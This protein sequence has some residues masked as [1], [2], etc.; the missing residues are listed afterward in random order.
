MIKHKLIITCII[1]LSVNINELL[2]HCQVPCGIY[3]DAARIVQM[4]EDIATIH[5]K[6]PGHI[7]LLSN[8]GPA[9]RLRAAYKITALKRIM[10]HKKDQIEEFEEQANINNLIMRD[11]NSI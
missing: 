1:F 10:Y 6:L 9:H 5:S 11:D 4:E 3:N 2:A 7:R 8:F